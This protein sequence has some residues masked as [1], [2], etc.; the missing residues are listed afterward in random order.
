MVYANCIIFVM[1]HKCM[2]K[3]IIEMRTKPLQTL[4]TYNHYALRSIIVKV[5]MFFFGR[6]WERTVHE[7][8]FRLQIN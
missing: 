5:L 3:L 8:N 2:I 7:H 1:Q 4:L 6:L